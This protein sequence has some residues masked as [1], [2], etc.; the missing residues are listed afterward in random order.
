LVY[1]TKKNLA[2]LLNIHVYVQP[3]I[4]HAKTSFTHFSPRAI[5]AI[6][7]FNSNVLN[8]LPLVF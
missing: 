8:Y 3:L 6:T 2:T 1:C 4:L 5:S 7:E